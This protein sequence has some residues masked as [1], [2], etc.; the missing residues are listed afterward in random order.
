MTGGARLGG[1]LAGELIIQDSDEAYGVVQFTA[2]SAQ[3]LVTV[4]E[5]VYDL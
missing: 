3:Q 2:D 1:M 4:S 5:Q